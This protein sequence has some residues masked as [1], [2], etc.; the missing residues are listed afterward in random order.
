MDLEAKWRLEVQTAP[1]DKVQVLRATVD[2]FALHF[3]QTYVDVQLK[4]SSRRGYV[5]YLRQI[6][7]W[8]EGAWMRSLTRQDVMTWRA[9]L[10]ASGL[11]P[12]TVNNAMGVLGSMC[13]EALKQG[14][15]DANPCQDIAKLPLE[16]QEYTWWTKEESDRF[17]RALERTEPQWYPHFAVLLL[18]GMRLGESLALQWSDID[19]RR[20]RIS[21][22]RNYTAGMVAT[23]KSGRGRLI[24]CSRR[25][26]QILKAAPRHV[27]S[28]LCF[29][30]PDGAHRN[31]NMMWKPMRRARIRAN[32]EHI[33]IHD[34][35]HSFASQMASA[36]VPVRTLQEMLGHADIK[37]TMRYAHLS[38]CDMEAWADALDEPREVGLRRMR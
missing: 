10:A 19:M 2:T 34:L 6:A 30:R 11:A 24:V 28:E 16:P 5:R 36:G 9:E 4:P 25:L 22:R 8:W 37:M 7:D 12:K 23:P 1:E 26:M 31:G 20:G 32:L 13:T 15:L 35:R 38:P 17:L 29:P 21:I 18:T 27:N 14:Y 33:R 3:K